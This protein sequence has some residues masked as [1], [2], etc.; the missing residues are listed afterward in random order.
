ML[1]RDWHGNSALHVGVEGKYLET[2][3]LLL[4]AWKEQ[5]GIFH[6]TYD[7]FISTKYSLCIW[8]NFYPK[9]PIVM[10]A[11]SRYYAKASYECRGSFPRLKAWTTLF[12]ATSQQWQVAGGTAS[13]L[14]KSDVLSHYANRPVT[15]F[16]Y[17]LKS[18]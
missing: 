10:I 4:D 8:R 3:K 1:D 7:Y 16:Y 15:R 2:V 11:C 14:T 13:D 5:S 9:N 18:V 17:I 6:G 12:Q